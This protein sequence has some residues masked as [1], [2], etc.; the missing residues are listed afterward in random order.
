MATSS[1]RIGAA[2]SL[3]LVGSSLLSGCTLKTTAAP[4][5]GPA[6]AISG[7]VH[8]G[9]SP[10]FG[11]KVYLLA[12]DETGYGKPS[13]SLLIA[14]LTGHPPDTIG[15]YVLTDAGGNFALNSYT[16]GDTPVYDY[17]CPTSSTQVYVYVS[18]GNPGF[19]TDNPHNGLMAALGSCGNLSAQ[20]FI[21]VNE[22][23]TVAAAYALSGFALDATDIA[24]SASPL[25]I[26]GLQN[27]FLNA[28]QLADTTYGTAN[29]TTPNINGTVDQQQIYTLA[30]ILASCINTDGADTGPIS[31]TVC[32]TLFHAATT[33]G[34]DPIVPT[35]TATAA[36][37]IA[38]H[39]GANVGTLTPLSTKTSPFPQASN[40]PTDLTL[41]ISYSV[42]FLNPQESTVGNASIAID[43][44]GNAWIGYN[45]GDGIGKLSSTGAPAP[46]VPFTGNGTL[47]N[48]GGIA[49][50]QSG[51]VWVADAGNT[52]VVEFSSDGLTATEETG[53]TS[54]VLR[55][56][57]V[58]IDGGG[59]VWADD[60]AGTNPAIVQINLP[61]PATP[62]TLGLSSSGR[63]TGL[64]WYS[65]H[66]LYA[67]QYATI[68]ETNPTQGAQ[69]GYNGSPITLASGSTGAT[70]VAV[71]ESG[72]A[73][74][75]TA[76]GDDEDQPDIV[77]WGVAGNIEVT[78]GGLGVAAG[79]AI[80]GAGN[81]WVA[82]D[83]AAF[84]PA[85]SEFSNA[86]VALSP[87]GFT[88]GQATGPTGIAVDGSG[89]VW[90]ANNN[91]SGLLTVS[92]LIGAA[93]PVVTPI[94]AGLVV[95]YS[96]GSRP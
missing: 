62:T 50:D 57:N 46:G 77:H 71:D 51:S 54:P 56:Y 36:I 21:E 78:G 82:N 22:V 6:V 67:T 20:T 90:V 86:G 60:E 85:I 18:G 13:D 44:G 3:L 26:Q 92:E 72:T 49:I 7:N 4:G 10:I 15:S 1:L 59:G 87:V 31:P 94:S 28:A 64:A 70:G 41:G 91:A 75:A 43:A 66:L 63:I 33:G 17:A 32:Y 5:P 88:G 25:S 73:W 14:A 30:N 29:F 96:P 89:D 8:G 95:P 52:G 69:Y 35:D 61:F 19:G 37:N 42:S 83:D 16:S 65:P 11:A 27:A 38:H 23:T 34:S 45:R 74:V 9:Q 93:V 12:A 55:A 47:G 58:A 80:D 53:G 24:S 39:P 2:F 84:A 40:P 68:A 48:P 76:L 81:V 79:I